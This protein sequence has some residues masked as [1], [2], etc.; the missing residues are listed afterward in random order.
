MADHSDLRFNIDWVLVDEIAVGKAPIEK[1]HFNLLKKEGIKSI[2]S[3]S[4]ENETS[5][6]KILFSEFNHERVIL[7]DH[8]SGRAPNIE[9]LNLALSTLKK[10]H[11]LGPVYVHCIASMERSPL[12]CIAWLIKENGLNVEQAMDYMMQIHNGTNP[13]PEQLAILNKLC[14]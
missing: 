1:S 13:L 10:L 11:S 8:R 3:L 4:K 2:L 6:S 14:D 9:E 12:I 7:P 5:F